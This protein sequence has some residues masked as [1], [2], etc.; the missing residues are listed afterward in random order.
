MNKNSM[1]PEDR[2]KTYQGFAETSRKWVSV[3]DTKAG[4]VSAMNAVLLTFIWTGAKLCAETGAV[5]YA[6]TVAT[7]LSI[8]SLTLALW[9]VLPRTKLSAIFGKETG[10]QSH[11][12]PISFFAHVAAAYPATAWEAYRQKVD[13]MDE[14]AF[15]LEALEQHFTIS[16]TLQKKSSVLSNAGT[17]LIGSVFLTAV[18]LALKG[19][20]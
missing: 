2:F 7:L 15:A 5:K 16:H 20:Y 19:S 14:N 11:Y 18:A 4:F 6:A 9:I 10:Y 3:Y 17:F 1:K 8:I 13:A 12:A